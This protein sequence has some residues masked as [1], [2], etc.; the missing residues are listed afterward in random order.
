MKTI[1]V[2]G[3]VQ[4]TLEDRAKRYVE[5]STDHRELL[6]RMLEEAWA[7]GYS[8]GRRACEPEDF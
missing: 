8:T 6:I 2:P 5:S 3:H 1:E 7:E 4:R